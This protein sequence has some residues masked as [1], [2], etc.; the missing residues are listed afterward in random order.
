MNLW[1]GLKFEAH[2]NSLI[3]QLVEL[4]SQLPEKTFVEISDALILNG[5][6]ID[7]IA[8]KQS[9][10]QFERQSMLAMSLEND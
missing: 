7:L 4:C 6:M 5:S 10:L 8:F 2:L 9:L 3:V 1:M